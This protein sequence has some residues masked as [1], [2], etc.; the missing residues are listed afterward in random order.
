MAQFLS[1][2]KFS[3]RK[4]KCI[5]FFLSCRLLPRLWM[6]APKKEKDGVLMTAALIA[7]VHT[8]GDTCR[9]RN[10]EIR[11][12]LVGISCYGKTDALIMAG[13]ITNSAHITEYINL[14]HY[15]KKYNRVKCIIPQ[16]GNHDSRGT[17]IYADFEEACT[18]FKD[19]C[20]YCGIDTIKG[21][22]YYSTVVKGCPVLVLG[23]EEL[24]HNQAKISIEQLKWLDAQLADAKGAC[25]P[26]FVVCHQPPCGRNGAGT[27]YASEDTHVG[28]NTELLDEILCSHA[29]PASPIIYVSGHMHKLGQ[30]SYECPTA[31]LYFL[32]LPSFLYS[33]GYGFLA[34]VYKDR[35]VLTGTDFTKGKVL[36][37]YIYEI[38]LKS[39]EMNQSTLT[40]SA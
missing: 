10:N 2:I 4:K 5:T 1:D 20:A 12:G 39:A 8:D 9:D 35:V 26:I 11:K 22:N 37:G 40:E 28:E 17:S 15:L 33:F 23:T 13:D 14:K 16:M 36:D 34:E 7:D 38:P 21:K 31:G 3:Q 19:F 6:N 27:V 25:S 18:L 32:N 24:V 30:Y 29:D